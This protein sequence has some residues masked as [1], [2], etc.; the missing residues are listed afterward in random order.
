MATLVLSSVGTAL[1]GPVGAAIG[2]LIG[3]SID[4][5]LLGGSRGPRVGDLSVQTSSY[6]TQIPRVYGKMRV[7]G[8]I[9]WSTDLVQSSEVVGVKG[10]PDTTFSYSVSFAVAVSS[11]PIRSIGRIWADG[12]L[13][14]DTDG[15]FKVPATL[16][17]HVGGEDQEI[18]PLIASIEG[19]ETTPVGRTASPSRCDF[20]RSSLGWNLRRS[21]RSRRFRVGYGEWIAARWIVS[22][23][24]R[25]CG[26]VVRL[27]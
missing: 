24:S 4:Q 8:S 2:A 27:S 26:Q 11:R 3:Q 5:Q 15:L 17:V 23:W 22:S 18:D 10:Q 7:A 19:I 12:K 20:R 9:V 13:I 1:G 16:R 25:S 21:C 14:R 6:G